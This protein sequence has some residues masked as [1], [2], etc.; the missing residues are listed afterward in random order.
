MYRETDLETAARLIEL[1]GGPEKV[2]ALVADVSPVDFE[3]GQ[4]AFGQVA[5]IFNKIG[6]P[7]KVY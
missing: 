1:L 4:S 7:E 2:R 6:G 3:Y 5:T